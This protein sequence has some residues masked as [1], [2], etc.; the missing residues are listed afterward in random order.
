[1]ASSWHRACSWRRVRLTDKDIL[2]HY[3]Q[4]LEMY[5]VRV[6]NRDVACQ[7]KIS[8]AST[9]TA[10]VLHNVRPKWCLNTLS[11]LS[12]IFYPAATIPKWR[13]RLKLSFLFEVTH[14]ARWNLGAQP[15]ENAFL[16]SVRVKCN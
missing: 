13:R 16:Q 11:I 14:D 8:Q 4:P 1:M 10:K 15:I 3:D 9:H 12:V 2:G 7:R 5:K 6:S